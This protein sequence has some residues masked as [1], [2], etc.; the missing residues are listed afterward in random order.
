MP[1]LPEVET[2][3]RGIA[4]LISGKT[5]TELVLRTEKLRWPLDR[6]LCRT[7]PGQTILSVERRAKY[8]LLHTEQ[9]ALILHLGM[10]GSLR[11]VPAETTENK[12]DHV[13]LI[14]TDGS[15]L[16]FTDPRKFGAL[17]WTEAEPLQHPLLVHLGPEPLSTAFTGE[18]LYQSSRNRK[19][20][21]KP[22]VMDQ[23]LVVG[24]GNIYASEALFGAGIDPCVAAGKISRERYKKLVG[25]IKQVLQQAIAA[26]GTTIND[27]KQSDG[28]PGYFKQ[29]LRVY[30]REGQ[31]CRICGQPVKSIRL[32]Q[33]STFF[34]AN[35]QR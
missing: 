6:N 10:S 1:E 19:I 21:V 8:L 15:C 22:F 4:P 18:H 5:I 33:R 27:F 11:I 30:G 34:C 17:L 35:C 3:R 9:G 20:A 2:T 23:K 32:G 14:F 12:H 26:G 7:L 25:E 13:D 29:E 28:K 24:V 31:P 16:R